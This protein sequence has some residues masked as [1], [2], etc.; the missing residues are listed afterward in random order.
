MF[1]KWNW[2]FF[3]FFTR[4]DLLE[5]YFKLVLTK[6]SDWFWIGFSNLFSLLLKH[7]RHNL[8]ELVFHSE[9]GDNILHF[10]HFL[11]CWSHCCFYFYCQK[12]GVPAKIQFPFQ[13][14]SFSSSLYI[15]E[16]FSIRALA[17]SQSI[18]IE[19]LALFLP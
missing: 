11:L 4:Q 14:S 7:V 15:F 9:L 18:W 17:L 8:S 16:F 12:C 19:Y 10:L 1:S 5:M 6:R 2:F 3:R 13:S